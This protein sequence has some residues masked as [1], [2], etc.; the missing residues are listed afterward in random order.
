MEKIVLKKLCNKLKWLN[1]LKHKFM[2]K[3]VL[4]ILPLPHKMDA[5]LW[6]HTFA[7]ENLRSRLFWYSLASK[8]IIIWYLMKTYDQVLNYLQ[9][10][11]LKICRIEDDNLAKWIRP[12]KVAGEWGWNAERAG[13]VPEGEPLKA[14]E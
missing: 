1:Y 14:E 3:I 4:Y 13:G 9:L 11:N 12:I 7:L 10:C 8:N 2:F 6:K 5:N